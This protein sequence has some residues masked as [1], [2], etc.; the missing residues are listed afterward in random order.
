MILTTRQGKTVQIAS[1]LGHIIDKFDASPAL[2][3]VP[4]STL[5]NWVREF[6]RWA[7]NLR[8]VPWYGEAR[9]REVIKKYELFHKDVN[10]SRYT[11]AKFH[12]LVTTYEAVI[13]PKDFGPIFKKQPRWEVSSSYFIFGGSLGITCL[14]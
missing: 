6:E 7:P 1:F 11:D 4:N 8:V 9:A 3:V 14:L 13:N 10:S 2:V 12:V 5:P